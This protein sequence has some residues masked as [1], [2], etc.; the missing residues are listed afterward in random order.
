MTFERPL[1]PVLCWHMCQPD[2]RDPVRDEFQF[3]WWCLHAIKDY[4]EMT[5]Q[6]EMHPGAKAI[7]LAKRSLMKASKLKIPRYRRNWSSRSRE[8]ESS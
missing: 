2:F 1:K 5:A 7:C 3:P 8:R 4:A 6:F